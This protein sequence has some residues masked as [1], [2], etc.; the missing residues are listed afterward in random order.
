MT[1]MRLRTAAI[2]QLRSLTT[3]PIQATVLAGN[4]V[5]LNES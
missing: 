2:A 3:S 4:Y 5:G 1:I